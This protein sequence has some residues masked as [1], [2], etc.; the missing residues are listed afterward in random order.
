[1]HTSRNACPD[2]EPLDQTGYPRPGLR[3]VT[4]PRFDG[5][6]DKVAIGWIGEI[7]IRGEAT[8]F[9]DAPA[10][11]LAQALCFIRKG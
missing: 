2:G 4:G 9:N 5:L 1:M 3:A 7:L 8:C 6:L 11:V 10:N